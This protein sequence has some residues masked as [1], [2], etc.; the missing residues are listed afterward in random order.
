MTMQSLRFLTICKVWGS[1]LYAKSEVFSLTSQTPELF[2]YM[3]WEGQFLPVRRSWR[4]ISR[5]YPFVPV[6]ISPC[7]ELCKWMQCLKGWR[8][9]LQH[10]PTESERIVHNIIQSLRLDKPL[11]SVVPTV[12]GGQLVT[13]HVV[14]TS[15]LIIWEVTS[16][17]TSVWTVTVPSAKSP[18]VKFVE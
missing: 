5:Y 12:L 18:V 17:V 2:D 15:P 14:A 13:P 6:M 16:V 4:I 7:I 1:W 9:M 3:I 8:K 11:S 10:T